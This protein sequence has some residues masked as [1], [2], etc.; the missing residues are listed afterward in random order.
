[1][2]VLLVTYELKAHDQDYSTFQSMLQS[3]P[4]ISVND[5][6][7]LLQSVDSP[8]EFFDGIWP[9]VDPHDLVQIFEV[10]GKFFNKGNDPVMEWMKEHCPTCEPI[11]A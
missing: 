3:Y 6:T 4:N 1:M 2:P 10:N 7:I 5:T 9:Y 8:E 11:A